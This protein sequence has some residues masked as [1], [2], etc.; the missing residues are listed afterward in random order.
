MVQKVFNTKY[1]FVIYDDK[2]IVNKYPLSKTERDGIASS[3]DTTDYT[4]KEN[5]ICN[6]D[7]SEPCGADSNCKY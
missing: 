1:Y 6:R 4:N 3:E 7:H 2:N 5:K